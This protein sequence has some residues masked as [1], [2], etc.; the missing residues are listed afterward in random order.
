MAAKPLWRWVV[1]VLLL[2][3][4][5]WAPLGCASGGDPASGGGESEPT[6]APPAP[7]EAASGAGEEIPPGREIAEGGGGPATYTFREIWRRAL[8]PAQAWREGAYLTS[9]VGD[10]VND[11]GVP[12]TWRLTFIDKPDADVVLLMD[13]D[14]WGKV[15][16]Q[17]EV[18]GEGVKSFVGEYS[19][20]M[21]YDVIDSD[22]AV[23][24]G[25]A[26]LATRYD[27]AKTKDPRLALNHSVI[28]ATGPY[29]SYS[30]FYT[31]SAEYVSSRMD[32]LTGE[33]VAPEP[34]Q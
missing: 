6:T 20:P 24:R 28:D 18:T 11:D 1:L 17:K 14:A 33:V 27:L 23:T 21:P 2:T 4:V 5:A 7:T 31:S 34:P 13:V 19:K 25:K 32:A 29:W 26:D 16:E 9:A 3:A 10:M 8:P 30:L 12:S 15:T 22:D